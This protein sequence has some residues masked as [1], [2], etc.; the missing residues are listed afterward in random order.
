MQ[1]IAPWLI[2]MIIFVALSMIARKDPG[3]VSNPRSL[4]GVAPVTA[5]QPRA[6]ATTDC[7]GNALAI[8]VSHEKK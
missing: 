1:S 8:A 2:W 7:N 5:T 6:A 4:S 3:P